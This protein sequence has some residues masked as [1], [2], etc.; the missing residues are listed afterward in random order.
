MASHAIDGREA[1]KENVDCIEALE[2]DQ[3]AR[4]SA[5]GINDASLTWIS[6]E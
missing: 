2:W 5:V 6:W 1:R 3:H 4:A